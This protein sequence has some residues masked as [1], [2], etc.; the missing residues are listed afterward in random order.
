MVSAHPQ[1]ET[2]RAVRCA[3]AARL[4]WSRHGPGRVPRRAPSHRSATDRQ[5]HLSCPDDFLTSGRRLA[6]WRTGPCGP[7]SPPRIVI[8]HHDLS[9]R[10]RVSTARPRRRLREDVEHAP[11]PP[12]PGDVPP[13]RPGSASADPVPGAIWRRVRGTGGVRGL[14]RSRAVRRSRTAPAAGTPGPSA[15]RIPAISPYLRVHEQTVEA[16]DGR[17]PAP[18]APGPRAPGPRAPGP[19]AAPRAPVRPGPAPPRAPR[20]PSRSCAQAGVRI[21]LSGCPAAPSRT[22]PRRSA[23]RR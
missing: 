14:W 13:G 9:S 16:D 23:A 15:F 2:A 22:R 19:R 5:R 10:S 7:S 1:G 3:A 8:S 17:A 11:K 4:R 6:A 12:S 21:T 20:A 18:R